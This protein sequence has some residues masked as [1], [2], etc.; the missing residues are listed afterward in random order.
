MLELIVAPAARADLLAQWDF[1]ADDIHSHCRPSIRV[2]EIDRVI[3]GESV[4]VRTL[5]DVESFPAVEPLK[6]RL[7][8]GIPIWPLSPTR[9]DIV[10]AARGICCGSV[11]PARATREA[12]RWRMTKTPDASFEGGGPSFAEA[13]EGRL[14]G[15]MNKAAR[16]LRLSSG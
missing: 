1:Y 4:V 7:P 14:P 16:P 8:Q 5:P 10:G 6:P 2:D 9:R 13:T 11:T 15:V 12:T 3:R